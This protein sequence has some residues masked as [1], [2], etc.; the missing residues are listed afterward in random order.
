MERRIAK[1]VKENPKKFHA[2]KNSKEQRNRERKIAK[3]AKENQK[4]S[5]HVKTAQKQARTKIGFLKNR[6]RRRGG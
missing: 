1:E 4:N 5:M 2:C 3:E 6:M